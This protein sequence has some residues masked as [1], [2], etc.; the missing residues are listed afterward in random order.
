MNT[1]QDHAQYMVKRR[2]N[3]GC[4]QLR[5]EEQ[6]VIA[7]AIAILNNDAAFATFGTV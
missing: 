1:S 7:E 3:E 4:M 6:T 2:H 5:T